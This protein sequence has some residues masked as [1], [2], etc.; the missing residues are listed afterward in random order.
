MLCNLGKYNRLPKV[1]DM[2]FD[3]LEPKAKEMFLD[4]ASVCANQPKVFL[5]AAWTSIHGDMADRFLNGLVDAAL[6]SVVEETVRIHDVLRDLGR[7]KLTTVESEYKETRVWSDF[8]LK[9]LDMVG[10]LCGYI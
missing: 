4:I 2:S 7:K 8:F 5:V 10:P 3:I 9:Q 1:L 6:V